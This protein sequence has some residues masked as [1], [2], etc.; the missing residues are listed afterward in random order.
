MT[1]L[2]NP[3]SPRV[4]FYLHLLARRPDWTL[5]E[6]LENALDTLGTRFQVTEFFACLA[7]LSWDGLIGL[8]R[9]SWGE[10]DTEYQWK[11]IV[12]SPGEY[13]DRLGED[14]GQL[15]IFYEP[16]APRDSDIPF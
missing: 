4:R 13:L 8:K 16:P 5:T 2:H 6:I 14:R 10:L 3:Y 7:L 11:I 1:R 15:Q 9:E 12:S